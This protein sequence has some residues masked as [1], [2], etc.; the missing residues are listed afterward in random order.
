MFTHRIIFI[1]DLCDAIGQLRVFSVRENASKIPTWV[2]LGAEEADRDGFWALVAGMRW[3]LGGD[4]D[5]PAR[6]LWASASFPRVL[7]VACGAPM[8]CGAGSS[9]WGVIKSYCRFG[10]FS[11]GIFLYK[12]LKL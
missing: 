11:E 2:R 12:F 5:L 9:L 10:V 7:S 6:L 1:L 4:L 3:T 8:P